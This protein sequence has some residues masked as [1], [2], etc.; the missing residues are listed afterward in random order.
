M[1]SEMADVAPPLERLRRAEGVDGGL[2]RLRCYTFSISCFWLISTT[3]TM[4]AI[5][6]WNEQHPDDDKPLT[7]EEEQELAKLIH[8]FLVM[9]KYLELYA[10]VLGGEVVLN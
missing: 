6:Q 10:D 7:H 3:Y 9:T 5:K 1:P 4:P 8:C 2:L